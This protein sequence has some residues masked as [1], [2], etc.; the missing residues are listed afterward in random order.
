LVLPFF[1]FDIAQKKF[2]F[3]ARYLVLIYTPKEA[4][5]R[6]FVTGWS[7]FA[8]QKKKLLGAASL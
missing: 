7:F 2:C 1:C 3:R 6:I 5:S 4:L 8:F